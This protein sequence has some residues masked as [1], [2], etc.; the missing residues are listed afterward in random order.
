MKKRNMICVVG[1]F[2]NKGD[3]LFY[4]DKMQLKVKME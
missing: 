1:P 4:L 2:P 3:N